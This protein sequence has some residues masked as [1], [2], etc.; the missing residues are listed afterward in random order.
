MHSIGTI[1]LVCIFLRL[2]FFKRHG[3]LRETSTIITTMYDHMMG[4][5]KISNDQEL[6]QSDPTLFFF[7][8]WE[9]VGI[10]FTTKSAVQIHLSFFYSYFLQCQTK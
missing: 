1:T 4:S 8:P 3:F 2:C 10:Y 5:K 7:Y 9:Y 6:I